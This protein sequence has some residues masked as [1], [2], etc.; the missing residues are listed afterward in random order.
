MKLLASFIASTLAQGLTDERNF[1]YGS[2]ADYGLGDFD[3][4][5]NFDGN[6]ADAYGGSFYDYDEAAQA[7]NRDAE[8]DDERKG[9][10]YF[11][12]QAATTSTTTT[13]TTHTPVGGDSC[14][15]CDQMTY[16]DCAAK[17]RIETCQK[18]DK[19]CC[20][21]EIRETAQQ[22]QQLCTGCKSKNA[23]ENLRDENFHFDTPN[24][25]GV[26]SSNEKVYQCRPDYRQQIV[27]KHATKQSV[28]RQC[29]ATCD[30][31]LVVDNKTGGY[32][33]GGA[34][35]GA[36]MHALKFNLQTNKGDYPWGSF[37]NSAIADV[38]DG[39]G[40][41]VAQ[42]TATETAGDVTDAAQWAALL[43]LY[44][45]DATNGRTAPAGT[46]TSVVFWGLQGADQAWWSSNLKDIQ[47]RARTG[48]ANANFKPA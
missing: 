39:L 8:E 29:F 5:Y 4:N 9:E 37:Y 13:T 18:G 28:C 30:P 25:L 40:I 24:S 47:T 6:Y 2:F 33:F 45:T 22:L 48:D 34:A 44:S 32:C 3:A 35:A 12:T 1:D 14:W 26:T 16:A 11:F 43:N 15:K 46:A 27:G 20:F 17:G 23:C 36:N 38:G 21:I 42:L 10:R 19:N 31:T 41:P 7:A